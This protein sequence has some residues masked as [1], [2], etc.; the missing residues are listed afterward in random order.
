M[1][2]LPFAG[3]KGVL[4]PTFLKDNSYMGTTK[5][6]KKQNR[7]IFRKGSLEADTKALLAL[8]QNLEEEERENSEFR[9]Q[10]VLL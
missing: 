4:R 9:I 7:K 6:T 2:P 3:E 1:S 8:F 5:T 10:N